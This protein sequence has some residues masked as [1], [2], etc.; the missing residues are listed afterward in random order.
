MILIRSSSFLREFELCHSGIPSSTLLIPC[1]LMLKHPIDFQLKIT[2]KPNMNAVQMEIFQHEN[3]SFS[4]CSSFSSIFFAFLFFCG[5]FDDFSEYWCGCGKVKTPFEKQ[6]SPSLRFTSVG[7]HRFGIQV[8]VFGWARTVYLS[9]V[10][11][12]NACF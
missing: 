7:N 2:M 1:V 6:L 5:N 4:I 12:S 10:R 3:S 9:S 8:N 11:F